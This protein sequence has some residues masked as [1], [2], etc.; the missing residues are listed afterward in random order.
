MNKALVSLCVL[1]AITAGQALAEPAS[2]Q[3]A[4]AK[5]AKTA[6]QA[7]KFLWL[8]EVE[9]TKPLAWVKDKNAH[10]ATSIKSYPGFD[11]LVNNSL[12]ILNSKDRIPYAERKGEYLYNFWKDET[13]VRGIYR[14][15]SLAE[16]VKDEPKWETVLDIDAIA[17]ADDVSWVYKDINCLAPKN[18]L[19]LVSLSR[20][21]ADAVEVREFNLTTK[22]FVKQGY[23]LPEAK[24]DLTWLTQ[25]QV[26]VATDFGGEQGMTDS[27]YPSVVKLWQRGDSLDK[28]K[29]IYQA[30]KSSV[31]AAAQ[32]LDDGQSKVVLIGDYLTFYT[33]KV[34]VYADDKLTKLNIP[35][36]ADIKGYF[37]GNIYIE[38]KSVLNTDKQQFV[39]GAVLYA[40]VDSLMSDKPEYQQ[41]TAPDAHSS[42]AQVA[43]SKNAVYV[44]LLEDVK[45]KLVRF[46]PKDDNNWTQT[47]VPFDANGSLTL[48]DIQQDSDDFFVDYNSFLEPSSFYQVKG[49]AL[50]INKLKSLPQQFAADKFVTKQYFATSKDGTK[51]PY[52]VVM[53]KNLKFNGKNPTLLYGYG[54]FEVSLKPKY[55]ADMGKNWLEQGGVY[56]LSNIRGGGEYGPAWHQAALKHNRHKAYEDF[57]AVAEDLISR[58]I[59]SSPHLGIQ[60]G[61]NGGLLMGAAL[62]RRPELYNAVV[63]QVP[64]LDMQRFSQ[65]LAGASWMGEYGNPEVAEDWAYIKTYSPYHNLDK[66]KQYP[67][68]FFT[69]ST[70]DDRVHPAHARK[71]VAKMESMGIDVLYYENMEGGHSGTADNQQK[72][73]LT[74]LVYAYLLQQLK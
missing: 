47:T 57:E 11:T 39:Q 22:S 36:D 63:C 18:D 20:G 21:G 72:A 61:S 28:A 73:E 16:Y 58:K 17:K 56:V 41:L 26:L 1:S 4:S 48:F 31:A 23:R 52:F 42:I 53:D 66:A 5:N 60:G 70:R 6:V 55:S 25:D 40:P 74:S 69:T 64:L 2:E 13:H 30:D 43:F 51:V 27:G 9:G 49:A 7:D 59:T 3:K 12:A 14:R 46:E 19:C 71:M 33:N 10:S 29:F 38:L 68:A 62:T 67:K 44:N 32:V 65:L 54:G 50:A 45:S 8:E 15:T 34:F 24:S 37:K 35:Q